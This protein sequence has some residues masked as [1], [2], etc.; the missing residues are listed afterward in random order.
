[1]SY[2]YSN[3]RQLVNCFDRKANREFATM[4]SKFM[5]EAQ[6]QMGVK[7]FILAGYRD[8]DGKIAQVK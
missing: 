4:A 5:E 6:Q 7:M 2:F 3:C 1:M 8:I